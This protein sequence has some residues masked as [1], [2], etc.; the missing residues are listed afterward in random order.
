[1]IDI[2]SNF[3]KPKKLIRGL[4]KAGEK[5]SK[6]IINDKY[7]MGHLC[8]TDKDCK[9]DLMCLQGKCGFKDQ[10]RHVNQSCFS[11]S[12]C[13][14]GLSCNNHGTDKL[15]STQIKDLQKIGI[16]INNDSS[17]NSKLGEKP[18]T[19]DYC[20]ETFAHCPSHKK[21]TQMHAGESSFFVRSLWEGIYPSWGPYNT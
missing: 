18:F 4:K 6:K 17:F 9:K 3:T 1:M 2:A 10:S 19:W 21:H 15:S 5:I 13:K 16:P 8:H 7:P 14:V 20:G 11:N 12:N